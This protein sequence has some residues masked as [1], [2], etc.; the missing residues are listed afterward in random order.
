MVARS[1]VLPAPR[2][3]ETTPIANQLAKEE[4]DESLTEM[5]KLGTTTFHE[6]TADEMTAWRDALL[7]VQK[8]MASRVGQ[9]LIDRINAAT[10]DGK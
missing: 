6:P 8:E 1:V 5:K 10:G 2:S 7:P 4:N 9:D 3:A